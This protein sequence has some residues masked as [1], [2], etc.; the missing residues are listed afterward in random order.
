M[1]KWFSG[2]LPAVLLLAGFLLLLYPWL[3]NYVNRLHSSHAVQHFSDQ[4]QSA[5]DDIL[6]QQLRLAQA[7]NA[8]LDRLG[9]SQEV[10][11][12]YGTILNF[13]NGMMGYISIP[14]IDVLLPIYHGVSPEVLQKGV[15]H[16]PQTAF[17]IGG[18][19]NHCVLTGHTGLPSARLFTD[20]CKLE[21]GDRFSITV[22]HQTAT[23][24]VDQ[25]KIVTPAEIQDLM[26][27]DGQDYCTLVTC[28]P[29]GINSH[30]LLVRG[31]RVEAET[32]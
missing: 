3:S 5:G 26:P 6:S 11:E 13:G 14:C 9:F 12:E 27:V 7:Y 29:Y 16:L 25:I 2:I 18:A 1:R 19:G 8:A 20:L 23:Y 24:Q 15:G 32:P 21:P 28:T 30:R 17:P 4:L 22:G 10:G 31:C